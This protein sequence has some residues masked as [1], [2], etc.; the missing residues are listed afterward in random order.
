MASSSLSPDDVRA[1]LAASQYAARFAQRESVAVRAS[2][3]QRLAESRG[4]L[5]MTADLLHR[6]RQQLRHH[7]R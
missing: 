4:C 2:V 3:D 7:G 5:R 1:R 6:L